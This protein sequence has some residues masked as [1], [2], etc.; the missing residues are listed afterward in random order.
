M[1]LVPFLCNQMF[2]AGGDWGIYRTVGRIGP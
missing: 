2:Y 1:Q